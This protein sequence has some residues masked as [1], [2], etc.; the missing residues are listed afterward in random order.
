MT[1]SPV[2]GTAPTYALAWAQNA[3]G[4]NEMVGFQ[5]LEA[6]GVAV[7]LLLESH[8]Y[9]I[10]A[11]TDLNGDGRYDGGEPM[12]YFKGIHPTPLSDTKAAAR[13]LELK[14]SATNG[15]PAGQSVEL[16]A[17][18]AELGAELT[19]TVGTIA[20]LNSPKFS[21]EAGEMGMWKPYDFLREHGMG[22]Y[23]LE[24]Y[25]PKK[26]PV[27]F[28]YGISGSF[29]DWRE[30][31]EGID[32]RK[33]QPWLF[34]Y[35]SGVRLD[36]SANALA[37]AMV[38]LKQRHGFDQMAV[39]AHSMGGLV[40]RG[41]IQRAVSKTGTNFI[42]EFISISTPW[43]GHQAAEKAVKHLK[44]PVPSWRDM[45]PGSAYLKDILERPLPKGTRHDLIFG[46]KS[47]GGMGLPDEND[48]VVSVV[49]ELAEQVQAGAASV[50]GY[51]LDHMAILRSP[52]V[53]RRVEQH[54]P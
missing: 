39:V 24:P 37:G 2:S 23:F 48:G 33:Y 50:Y 8:R 21:T 35:A 54:L 26:L 1:V 41:A 5:R 51:H 19:V 9:S 13:P 36:K 11:F 10:G 44:F 53:L 4:T 7:F 46:Y 52:A 32:R 40:S 28:V 30:M 45:A 16:P 42:P 12:D 29:Q 18:Y 38:L 14:L 43:A 3:A 20:D 47:S 17:E 15:L 22:V 31:V 6:D 27:L 49:S 25:H 34:L